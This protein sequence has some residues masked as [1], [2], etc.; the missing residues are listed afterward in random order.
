M[1]PAPDAAS[2]LGGGAATHPLNGLGPELL[3]E[4]WT[5]EEFIVVRALV[6]DQAV[7]MDAKPSSVLGTSR[8]RGTLRLG[9]TCRSADRVAPARLRRLRRD[10]RCA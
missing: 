6:V 9:L 2:L 10:H 7:I 4:R 1:R 5:D 3:T 8:R